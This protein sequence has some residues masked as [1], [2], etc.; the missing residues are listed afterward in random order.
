MRILCLVALLAGT[1]SADDKR[2][3]AVLSVIA[4]DAPKDKVLI[5]AA[6]KITETLRTHASAKSGDYR[7]KGTPKE[8]DAAMI[9]GECDP[10][11]NPCAAKLGAALGADYVI[12]GNLERRGDHAVLVLAFVDVRSKQ[13]IKSVHQTV[14]ATAD[15]AKLA[16]AAY[17]RLSARDGEVGELAVIANAQ[18]GEVWID[19]QIV[20]GLFGGRT[21]IQNLLKGSHVLAIRAAGYKP[22]EVDVNVETSTKQMVLLDPA[23]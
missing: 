2:S 6:Q 20:A 17:T 19:G 21:T 11:Q 10:M 23:E 1:A 5:N 18:R 4:R 8:V 9:A 14:A 12:A 15:A 3:V 7:L 16:R 22:F 13:R